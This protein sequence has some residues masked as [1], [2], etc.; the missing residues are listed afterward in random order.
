ML[1]VYGIPNC[2][3]VKKAVTALKENQLP[4]TFHDYKKHGIGPEK[5]ALWLTQQPKEILINRAGTTWKKLSD[6]QKNAIQD[7]ESAIALM[8]EKPSVIKRPIIEK[9]GKIVA[10]GWKPDTLASVV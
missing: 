5:L 3:T 6:E 2:D 8:L 1:T 10:V 9:E 7:N 4:F